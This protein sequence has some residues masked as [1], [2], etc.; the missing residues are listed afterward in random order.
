MDLP[1]CTQVKDV[2]TPGGVCLPAGAEFFAITILFV[3]ALETE[4]PQS[5]LL[6][7]L[8]E[9][10]SPPMAEKVCLKVELLTDTLRCPL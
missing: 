3:L 8:A 4:T 6:A 5:F 7:T 2:F 1:P 10:I 9:Q